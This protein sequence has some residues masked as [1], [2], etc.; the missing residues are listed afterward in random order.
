MEIQRE[1]GIFRCY[2][3]SLSL[4]RGWFAFCFDCVWKN[5]LKCFTVYA[6]TNHQTCSHFPVND[7]LVLCCSSDL[8]PLIVSTLTGKGQLEWFTVFPHLSFAS[9]LGTAV[10]IVFSLLQLLF[11]MFFLCVLLWLAALALCLP[12]VCIKMQPFTCWMLLSP[13]WTLQQRK[14][15][16]IS[17]Y[18]DRNS[19]KQQWGG[20]DAKVQG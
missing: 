12:G 1:K 14:R 2:Q 4:H 17:T 13:T 3:N 8:W 10:L 20:R 15:S 5:S 9:C 18:A 7:L 6:E 16:L 19:F 11:L